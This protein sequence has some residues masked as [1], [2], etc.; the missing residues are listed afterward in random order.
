MT[1]SLCS[2]GGRKFVATIGCGFACTVLVWF[3]K[4]TPDVFQWTVISTVGA[5]IAGNVMQKRA[6]GSIVSQGVER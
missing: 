5:F 6:P 4:I 3:G 2:I 1:L